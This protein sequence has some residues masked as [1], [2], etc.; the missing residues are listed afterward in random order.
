M[1]ITKP[2][3]IISLIEQYNLKIR[4]SWGQNF[5]TSADIIQ[6]IV[7]AAE[8]RASDHILEVG[9]GLG[10]MTELLVQQ[11]RHV[12]ALEID[13]RLCTLLTERLGHQKNFTL[14]EGDALQQNYE[15]LID[16]PFKVVANLPYYITSPFIIKLLEGPVQP[17]LAVLLVQLEVGRRLAAAPGTKDYGA[18]SVAVQYRC[19]V[20]QVGRV[21]AGNFFPPPKVESAIVRLRWRQ[22]PWQATN[23]QLMSRLV[24][25]AFGQRR[26]MLKGVLASALGIPGDQVRAALSRIGV[27]EDTRGE[28][29]SVRQFAHLAD[30]LEELMR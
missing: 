16:T 14:I 26:K 21:A 7:S 13:P 24:R 20:E 19:E 11:A 17:V 4:K 10:T 29:L 2:G 12:T 6:K 22:P 9:P 1:D 28:K 15:K 8:L 27:S 5:L 23:P 18:L 25:A 30:E 3:N